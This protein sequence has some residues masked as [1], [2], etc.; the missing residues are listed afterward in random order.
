MFRDGV[1]D[2]QIASVCQQEIQD[3]QAG[4]SEYQQ[5]HQPNWSVDWWRSVQVVYL[6]VTQRHATRFFP[7]PTTK[8]AH[9]DARHGQN[10]TP[11][12]VVDRDITHEYRHD[13]Y[14]QARSALKGTGRPAHYQVIRNDLQLDS[15]AMATL[16]HSF[17]YSWAPATKGIS[18]A[19]PAYAADAALNYANACK[20]LVYAEANPPTQQ[21]NQTLQQY[22]T[23]CLQWALSLPRN[24]TWNK[25]GR[26]GPWSPHLNRIMFFT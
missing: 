18:Y 5:Q 17:S 4:L 11:G 3:I 13:L 12:L 14:M 9:I 6:I 1:S 20:Y 2:S 21:Q 23:H 8:P 19:T 25:V 24:S 16:I 7:A 26:P 10:I 22:R 15:N